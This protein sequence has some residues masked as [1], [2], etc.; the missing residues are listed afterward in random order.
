MPN[1]I[2][3]PRIFANDGNFQMKHKAIAFGGGGTHAQPVL[4]NALFIPSM[5]SMVNEKTTKTMPKSDCDLTFTADIPKGEKLSLYFSVL[6][7]LQEKYPCSQILNFYDIMCKADTHYD[8]HQQRLNMVNISPTYIGLMP[9]LHAYAHGKDCQVKFS[10]KLV[11]GAGTFD[12]EVIERFW[13]YISNHI[14][15]TQRQTLENRADAI[16]L[17]VEH[18]TVDKN[19]LF[20]KS[21]EQWCKAAMDDIAAIKLEAAEAAVGSFYL[22]PYCDVVQENRKYL[23]QRNTSNNSNIFKALVKNKSPDV[24]RE[25]EML[26]SAIC[27]LSI[28]FQREKIRSKARK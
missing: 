9:A 12:G 13:V 28:K 18:A 22:K 23:N 5:E 16:F 14:G 26:W 27:N 7:H 10:G 21:I 2:K 17:M 4:A 20:C 25:A 1:P 11:M 15:H 19:K 3:L 6:K 8:I 24:L